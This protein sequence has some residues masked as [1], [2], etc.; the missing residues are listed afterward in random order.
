MNR[1]KVEPLTDVERE[2][3]EF[4]KDMIDEVLFGSSVEGDGNALLQGLSTTSSCMT[5]VHSI[6]GTLYCDGSA[7]SKRVFVSIASTSILPGNAVDI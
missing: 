7:T 5:D 2:Y 3:R 1:E 6:S 4:A